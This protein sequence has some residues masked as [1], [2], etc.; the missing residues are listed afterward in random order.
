[1]KTSL[2]R[3]NSFTSGEF[4]HL[5]K[6]KWRWRKSTVPVFSACCQRFCIGAAS[7]LEFRGRSRHIAADLLVCVLCLLAPLG[8]D[9][10]LDFLLMEQLLDP[11]SAFFGQAGLAF[12]VPTALLQHAHHGRQV[13]G[14]GLAP[15]GPVGS[16]SS[17]PVMLPPAS[18]ARRSGPLVGVEVDD[19]RR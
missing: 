17:V 6:A 18:S 10:G 2:C 9:I 16:W 14:C 12:G 8:V 13:T 3:V 15:A 4:V 11:M 1:M 5:M 7:V 19:H